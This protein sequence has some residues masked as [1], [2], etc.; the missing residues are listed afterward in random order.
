V[1]AFPELASAARRQ[2]PESSAEIDRLDPEGRVLLATA[3][4][5]RASSELDASSAF[6]TMLHG[7]IV[8]DVDPSVRWL[9]ARAVC[10][11]LRHSEICRHMAICHGADVP[12]LAPPRRVAGATAG[13]MVHAIANCAI[14]E[15]IASAFLSRS[16]EEAQTELSHAAVRELLEDEVDHARI[17]WAILGGMSKSD[18]QSLQPLVPQLVRIVRQVWLDAAAKTGNELPLGHGCLRG[19]DLLAVV[20]GAFRELVIP[21]LSHVGLDPTA[22]LRELG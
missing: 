11:E 8:L 19:D 15:T 6:A 7:I 22:A 10:D 1:R 5:V 14:S 18:L 12:P 17:G 16:L 9:T 20:D 13:P 4:A 3:W 21:G 2:L